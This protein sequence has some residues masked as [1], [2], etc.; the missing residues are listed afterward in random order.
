MTCDSPASYPTHFATNGVAIFEHAL[1][2]RDL[3]RMAVAFAASGTTAGARQDALPPDLIEWLSGHP[4]L[5]ELSNRLAG[6]TA[7]LVRVIAFDKSAAANWFVPWHQ[8]RSIAVLRQVE[9]AGFD[10]WTI[11]DG[12]IQVEPPVAIL[13]QMVTLRVHLDDINEDNGPL[14]VLPGSHRGGRLARA[15][16][17]DAVTQGKPLLCLAAQ[18][19]ILAMRPLI[20]HRSQRARVA[21]RRRVLHLEFATTPLA[22]GLEWS[23][24][25]SG[26]APIGTG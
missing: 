20:L 2:A 24:P 12:F 23:L 8:D 16:V 21:A 18:G 9:C 3:E 14:E 11:K 26:L 5:A 7:R 22:P 25:S 6:A 17:A 10:N 13:E 4:V 19:D 1:T 15:A